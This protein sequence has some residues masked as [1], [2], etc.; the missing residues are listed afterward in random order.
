MNRH[1]RDDLLQ[2]A[3]IIVTTALAIALTVFAVP[4]VLAAGDDVTTPP[5]PTPTPRCPDGQIH[6]KKAGK[7]V[8]VK[9]SSLSDTDRY[10]AVRELA[11][12]QRY[13][14]ASL[15]LDA[16]ADQLDDRVLT[17]RG[18]LMRKTGR[19]D[20]ALTY[21]RSAIE[22]NPSNLLVRSYMGQG[23]VESGDLVAAR[24]QHEEILA[25]GGQGT[26]A[27]VSLRD[28]LASGRTYRY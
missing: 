22:K 7:C 26:W 25:R 6:D 5:A 8:P 9:S 11:Y 16:M 20:Q 21:Y 13:T 4:V 15:V 14:A 2:R 19:F 27:E 17:Y 18:F 1:E 3:R 12:A 28:A 10:Q 24:R 23:F